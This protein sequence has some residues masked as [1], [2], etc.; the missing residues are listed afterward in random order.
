VPPRPPFLA[1]TL[2][3][4]AGIGPWVSAA[5]ALDGRVRR[6]CRPLLVGDAW[7]L[8]RHLSRPGVRVRP[9]A[10]PDDFR[11]GPGVLN[12]LHVPHPR[13]RTL[14]LGRPQKVG[15]EAA[16]LAVRTAV[17]LALRRK[18]A[19]VVTGPA[20]KESLRA[21]GLPFAG[22]TEM[23]AA[24]TGS[25]RVEMLMSAGS[26]R[27]VLLTRHLPLKDVPGSLRAAEIVAALRL[28]DPWLR[29]T[30]GLKRRVRWAVCGLNPHAGDSGLL[31]S[32]EKRTVAPAVARLRAA[33]VDA[34]GP[35]PADVAWARHA[36]GDFDAVASLYHDQG[37]IPLKTLHPKAVVNTTVGLPFVRT[38]PG[39]GTAFDLAAD[40]YRRAD[41]TATVE[42]ALWA[43]RAAERHA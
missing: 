28:V 36:A 12:V 15:G 10:H 40:R 19:A 30:L 35:L 38:S 27:T 26:L 7:V 21:A 3:D 11:A 22:H 32:E 14:V 37:M 25:G 20:S 9:L 39:H 33:R 6:L 42:A 1:F 43:L 8:H 29:A 4:P 16:A 23:L 5:A 2:G 31:G 24:L 34:V 18:V 17:G 41:A 13:I